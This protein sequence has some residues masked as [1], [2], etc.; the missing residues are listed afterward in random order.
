VLVRMRI[1]SGYMIRREVRPR[2]ATGMPAEWR[3]PRERKNVDDEGAATVEEQAF[4]S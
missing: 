3:R 2:A 1:A 4:Y